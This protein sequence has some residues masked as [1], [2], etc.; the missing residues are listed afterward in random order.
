MELAISIFLFTSEPN[1]VKFSGE[2]I[3]SLF[4]PVD[5]QKNA[6]KECPYVVHTDSELREKDCD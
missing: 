4:L 1:L 3:G 6:K 2:P 5:R